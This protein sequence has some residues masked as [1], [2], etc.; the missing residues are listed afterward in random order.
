MDRAWAGLCLHGG[1]YSAWRGSARLPTPRG[2]IISGSSGRSAIKRPAKKCTAAEY[3]QAPLTFFPATAAFSRVTAQMGGSGPA[4]VSPPTRDSPGRRGFPDL[5][6][7]HYRQRRPS[8]WYATDLWG[9]LF[10]FFPENVDAAWEDNRTSRVL[11]FR[12]FH[13]GLCG[14]DPMRCSDWLTVSRLPGA[15]Q[16]QQSKFGGS[17]H[18]FHW[19]TDN[20]DLEED[21]CNNK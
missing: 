15:P 12:T 13:G 20:L 17:V 6:R 16:A 2:D 9:R 7:P 8:P 14:D 21:N 19:S 5:I 11:L 4:R 10:G 1:I 3:Q 18:W